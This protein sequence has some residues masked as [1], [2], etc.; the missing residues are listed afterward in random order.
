MKPFRVTT[1]DIDALAY[2]IE[3]TSGDRTHFETEAVL[4]WLAKNEPDAHKRLSQH[5]YLEQA[6]WF[7]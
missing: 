3:A 1:E 4:N 2:A 7:V 6:L 5:D